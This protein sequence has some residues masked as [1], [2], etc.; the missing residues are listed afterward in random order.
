MENQQQVDRFVLSANLVG[1]IIQYMG[2]RPYNEVAPILNGIHQQIGPQLP[3]P[4]PEESAA[5][6]QSEEV[7]PTVQ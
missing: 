4:Q 2:A 3:P 6:A 7:P 5:G 1:A